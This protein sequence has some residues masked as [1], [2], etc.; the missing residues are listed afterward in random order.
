[1]VHERH[2]PDIFAERNRKLAKRLLIIGQWIGRRKVA[3]AD[4]PNFKSPAGGTELGRGPQEK[5]GA[6]FGEDSSHKEN[7]GNLGRAS[8]G[9]GTKA[10]DVDSTWRHANFI[11]L[12]GAKARLQ[13]IGDEMAATE[14][15]VGR[16]DNAL[17]LAVA[18]G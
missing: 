10:M 17:G 4:D 11:L 3:A 16:I 18:V 8:I 6:F 7:D 5:V 2:K 13:R 1:A 9:I 15:T 14:N 12:V